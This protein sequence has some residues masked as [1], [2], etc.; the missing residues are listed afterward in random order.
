[1]SKLQL[2]FV[3]RSNLQ[4][5]KS[6]VDLPK[7]VIY[8]GAKFHVLDPNLQPHLDLDLI[9][10][11]ISCLDL[12]VAVFCLRSNLWQPLDLELLLKLPTTVNQN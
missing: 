3:L 11:G 2:C 7:D 6:G 12:I 4:L 1:M 8:R 5:Y 9:C 10:G